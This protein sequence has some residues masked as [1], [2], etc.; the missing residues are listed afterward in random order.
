MGPQEHETAVCE[1]KRILKEGGEGYLMTTAGS[2]SYVD[3]QEWE[4]ILS[5]FTVEDR[6]HAP[7][8]MSRWALVRKT[9]DHPD[10]PDK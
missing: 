9:E 6:N 7:Y 4:S 1:I 2:I 10:T 3:D 5:N 8:R